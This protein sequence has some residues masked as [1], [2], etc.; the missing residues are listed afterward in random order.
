MS[1]TA[2]TPATVSAEQLRKAAQLGDAITAAQQCVDLLDEVRH[3][4]QLARIA[5]FKLQAEE[6]I[7][8]HTLALAAYFAK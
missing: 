3:R 7:T 2:T 4:P 5:R 8:Q 1:D 6:A